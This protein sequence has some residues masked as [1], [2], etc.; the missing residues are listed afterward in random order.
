MKKVLFLIL[1]PF[2]L[3]A[4]DMSITLSSYSFYSLTTVETSLDTYHYP[5]YGNSLRLNTDFS[6]SNSLFEFYTMYI[7]E[8]R[9]TI[10]SFLSTDF[11]HSSPSYRIDDIKRDITPDEFKSISPVK[12]YQNINQLYIKIFTDFAEFTIGRQI[13]GWGSG[14][15][16]NP[17]FF[18][19]F[20]IT[21]PSY[22]K[23]GMDALR[24]VLYMGNNLIDMGIIGGY[25][26]LKENDAA[27]LRGDFLFNDF[28][29]ISP[30]FIYF[31][32]N[33]KTGIDINTSI[34][35]SSVWIESGY[36]IAD[37]FDNYFSVVSGISY[38]FFG[39]YLF[40]TE[41]LYNSAGADTSS[42]YGNLKNNIYE[43]EGFYLMG[44]QYI[45]SNISYN[46]DLLNASVILIWNLED[47]SVY[48]GITVQYNIHENDDMEIGM[49]YPYG[50]SLYLN[51]FPQY[52]SEFGMYPMFFYFSFISHL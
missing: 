4:Y 2:G 30:S 6:Y 5:Y 9:V 19:T 14:Y 26:L 18:S 3:F 10:K 38:L 25:H 39:K 8:N 31:R 33:I 32:K 49:F 16:Y 44:K 36:T 20:Y 37:T 46:K 29:K 11:S 22:I 41:Y 48:S 35:G 50:K 1:L 12:F 17:L 52:R 27:Y 7:L 23:E 34:G 13:I 43:D 40:T 21:D 24:C 15:I 28:I 45:S 47:S 42:E 51:P